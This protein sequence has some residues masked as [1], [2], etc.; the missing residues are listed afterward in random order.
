VAVV[1]QLEK[2]LINSNKQLDYKFIASQSLG[3]GCPVCL[4]WGWNG[5]CVL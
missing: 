2:Y 4:G 1:N 5:P 3:C